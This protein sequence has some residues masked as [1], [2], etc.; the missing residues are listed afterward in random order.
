MNKQKHLNIDARA[1][2]ELELGK[3]TSF[4]AIGLLLEKDCTTISKEVRAHRVF[5]KTGAFGKAFNDCQKAFM[6]NC[7]LK[8]TCDRCT[9]PKKP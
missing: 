7:S 3:G 1:T 6:H 2:I 9:S 4:K 5:E 8:H